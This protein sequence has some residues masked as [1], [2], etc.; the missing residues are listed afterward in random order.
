MPKSIVYIGAT[1]C[2]TCKV[3]KPAAEELAK[4]FSVAISIRDYDRDLEPDEQEK[5][6]KVPTLR[7]VGEGGEIAEEWNVNQVASLKSWLEANIKLSGLD[8]F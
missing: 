5:V 2:A 1:W 6:T 4:R 8:D 3:I 7:I